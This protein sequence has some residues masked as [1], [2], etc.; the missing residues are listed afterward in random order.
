MITPL[1]HST[2]FTRSLI[3]LKPL[4][5][6]DSPSLVALD[7]PKGVSQVCTGKRGIDTVRIALI[8]RYFRSQDQTGHSNISP[9]PARD[10]RGP[11]CQHQQRQRQATRL[12]GSEPS[13]AR[14]SALCRRAPVPVHQRYHGARHT[15]LLTSLRRGCLVVVAD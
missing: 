4:Y 2:V 12:S 14:G 8:A 15:T 9:S 6:C 3:S 11:I 13:L 1:T 5:F 7:I 10:G